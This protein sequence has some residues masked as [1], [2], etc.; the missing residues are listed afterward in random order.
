M[1]TSKKEEILGYRGYLIELLGEEDTSSATVY[2]MLNP[3]KA[4]YTKTREEWAD[5]RRALIY[6]ARNT[7]E[8]DLEK[9]WRE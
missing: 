3:V 5:T 9:R 2:W 8:D 1:S 7:I 6:K 4:V